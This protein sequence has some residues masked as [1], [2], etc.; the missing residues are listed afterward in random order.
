MFQGGDKDSKSSWLGSIPK[1]SAEVNSRRSERQ[2][3]WLLAERRA[4]AK[5]EDLPP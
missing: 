2:V 3:G 4:E 1:P 5:L